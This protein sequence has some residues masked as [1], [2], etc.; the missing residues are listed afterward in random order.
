MKR[1]FDSLERQCPFGNRVGLAGADVSEPEEHP[2]VLVAEHN[3]PPN[4]LQLRFGPLPRTISAELTTSGEVPKGDYAKVSVYEAETLSHQ[5]G[6]EG[7]D[8]EAGNRRVWVAE[9]TKLA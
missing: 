4:A 6:Y 3:R 8:A 1:R 2:P 5:C 7:A 9:S